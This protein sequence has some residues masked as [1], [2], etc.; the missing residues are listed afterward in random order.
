[1]NLDSEYHIP[2]LLNQ[3]LDSLKTSRARLIVDVTL[4][5]GG[6]SEAILEAMP[7]NGVVVGIDRDKQAIGRATARLKRF[8]NRFIA[9]HGNF[10][11]LA[12]LVNSAR[13]GPVDGVVADL[14]V[15][16]LQITDPERG[17]MFSRSGPLLM[18]MGIN[19]Q[20]NAEEVVNEYPEKEL[21]DIIFQYGEEK[22]S[23]KIAR[24]IVEERKKARIESTQ[25]LA[26]I[27]GF[28]VRGKFAVKSL[29]R[30]FQ[31]IRVYVN[32]E[33]DSLK[34]LLPQA[35]DVLGKGGRLSVVSYHSLEDRIVK[36][37]IAAQENP[38]TCPP[39]LPACV[40]LKQPTLKKVGKLIIPT[41]DEMEKNPNSRS[42]KL[43]IAEKL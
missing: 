20:L 19:N 12:S 28:V 40:C 31:A 10:S 18:Q 26:D 35:K 17:F 39:E 42:A 38:C 32:K 34:E 21:A 14:G 33:L 13:L 2:V 15:S 16:T 27:V 25:Q 6:Y 9:M 29:A 3:V 11:Q 4:G 1:M 7:P 23:R 43:R 36:R 37:Y 5:D 30:V 24:K 41:Q 8:E 22:A